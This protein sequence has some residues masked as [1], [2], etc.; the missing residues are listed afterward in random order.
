MTSWVRDPENKRLVRSE[1][2]PDLKPEPEP[3][4]ELENMVQERTLSDIY[5]PS[6]AALPSC[7]VM[8]NLAPN[9]TFELKSHIL[10]SSL[11]LQV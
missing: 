10:R 1:S 5:Y 7:F 2:D 8:S 11:N 3:K 9:V 6:R 4:L